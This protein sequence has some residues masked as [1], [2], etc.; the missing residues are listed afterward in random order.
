MTKKSWIIIIAEA[1]IFILLMGIITNC[2]NKK[3]DLLEHNI[4]A[5]KNEIE[6]VEAKNGEL[7]AI[8]ESLILSESEVKE[9]LNLTKLEIKE[10]KKQLDDDI[11]YI[12]K[13]E[14]EI[15]I[16]DTLWLKPD[17]VYIKNDG[18]FVKTFEW[19]DEWTNIN[20]TINGNSITDSKLTLNHLNMDVPLELGLTDDYKFW[21]KSKNPYVNFTNINSAVLNNSS[22]KEKERHFQHGIYVGFG[23]QYG[24]FGSNWD[25]GPHFGYGLMY[26][27]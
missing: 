18:T 25:F 20:T 10:L 6:L 19:K 13:L 23:F 3:I 27:F 1:M 2:S 24:L 8:K 11:A 16:K 14:A 9:E 21:V 22:V 7:I 12:N 5:Y 17:T 4:G 26:N 15:S